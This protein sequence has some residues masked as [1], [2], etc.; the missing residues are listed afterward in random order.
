MEQL[1][2]KPYLPPTF[3]LLLLSDNDILR[4]SLENVESS[5]GNLWDWDT[6]NKL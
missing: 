4:T 1:N 6:F 5:V 2:V 3:S